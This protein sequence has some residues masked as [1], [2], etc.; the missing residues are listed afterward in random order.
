M[1][2]L[3]LRLRSAVFRD[4]WRE[5]HPLNSFRV[6]YPGRT[7][8]FPG[9]YRLVRALRPLH[10]LR[11]R[12]DAGRALAGYG[13]AQTEN[14]TGKL[15]RVKSALLLL[16]PVHWHYP[17]PFGYP[18][19]NFDRPKSRHERSHN[20]MDSV[21][22]W[23]GE[24]HNAGEYIGWSAIFLHAPYGWRVGPIHIDRDGE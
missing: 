16:G 1:T 14:Q 12:F 18:D 20:R 13:D 19:S 21:V 24:T 11:V 17:M 2:T 4:A 22:S 9:Y 8:P 3:E 23:D 7:E 6:D 10:G 15:I 5:A